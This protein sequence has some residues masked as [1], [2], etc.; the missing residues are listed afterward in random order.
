MNYWNMFFILSN[1][2]IFKVFNF[3]EGI[4]IKIGFFGFRY[5]VLR[6]SQEYLVNFGIVLIENFLFG[7]M[8]YNIK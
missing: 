8:F 3:F 5:D 2:Y 7:L 1:N 6:I 4:K